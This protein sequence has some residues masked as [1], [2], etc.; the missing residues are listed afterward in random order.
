[1]K[2]VPYQ[3]LRKNES[4][5]QRTV[6]DLLDA[7]LLPPALWTTFPAGWGH[8]GRATA[9]RL[10]GAGLK[11]GMPDILLFHRGQ[12]LG[13]ELKVPGGRLSKDQRDMHDKLR[14][15]GVPVFV[16]FDIETVLL[17]LR[18]MGLPMRPHELA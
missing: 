3:R 15:A 7:V 1:M 18:M 11:P 13:L 4:D 16:C 12:T 10:R 2:P 6:A 17:T 14:R 5:F 9:G 8:L